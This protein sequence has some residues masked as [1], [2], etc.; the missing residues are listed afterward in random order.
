M[1]LFF[2]GLR[3]SLFFK[4]KSIPA[5]VKAEYVLSFLL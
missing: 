2:K 1:P 3:L 4:K 5:T